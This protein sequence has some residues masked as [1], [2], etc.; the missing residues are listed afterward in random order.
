MDKHVGVFLI[1]DGSDSDDD[2]EFVL[3]V[4]SLCDFRGAST[5]HHMNVSIY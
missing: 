2:F 5:F 4:M 1:E 3:V